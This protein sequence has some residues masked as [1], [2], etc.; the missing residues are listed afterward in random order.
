[1]SSLNAILNTSLTGLFTSQESLRVTSNNIANVNTPDYARLKVSQAATVL[2]GESVGVQVTEITR[3]VDE[4]LMT[5]LRNANSATGEFEIQAEFHDRIQG[6]LGKPESESSFSAQLEQVYAAIAELT[7]NPSDA[8]RRQQMMSEMTSFLQHMD[9][10]AGQIQD[11]RAE[12]SDKISES[13]DFANDAL[14]RISELNPLLARAYATGDET[15]GLEGLMDQALSELSNYMDITINR[16]SNGTVWVS[17]AS[18]ITLV[19]TGLSQ[20]KYSSPG[21]VSS[22]TSFPSITS[23]KVDKNTLEPL[24][25]EIDMTTHIRSGRIRGLMDL[26]DDQLVDLSLSLG[27]MAARV[28]DQ[29]NAVHNQFSSTPPLNTLTGK[30]TFLNGTDAPGFT[31]IATFAVADANGDLVAK[32]IVDF[33]TAP[34]ADMNALVTQ[35]NAGLGGAGTVS[36]TNGVLSFTAT[37]PSH[38]AVIADSDTAPTDR[39]GRGFSHFFG[40]ND[41]ILSDSEGIYETGLTGTEAHN[42]TAGETMNFSVY[43][44]TGRELT[45]ITVN[46][47]GTTYNDMIAE[48]NNVAGLGAYFSFSLDSK[49]ALQWNETANYDGL[50]LD[51]RSD[52][53][54]AGSTGMG[55]T[56]I[57]GMDPSAHARAAQNLTIRRDVFENP[58]LMSIGKFD[59]TAAVGSQ[60]LTPGD[61]RGAL[62][63][64]D[65]E[66]KFVDFASA[67]ELKNT[68]AT[69][70]QYVARFLGNAGQMATRA[71]NQQADNG[72]LRTELSQKNADVSG[73]NMDEELANLIVY[74]NAYNAAAR[75]LSSVQELYDALLQAV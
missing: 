38:G 25:N 40:M 48:L 57:F 59:H 9:Q 15:G 4:F 29:F 66:T 32:T 24:S 53:T 58:G 62:A 13:V 18:G 73:V 72:A 14:V 21:I 16:Q 20:L 61:Q 5:A 27:E 54:N 2:Q 70:S 17:S 44:N 46:V 55:F 33:D 8:L 1:M 52:S 10:L 35:I 41:L 34:P 28:K 67:G 68:N 19:D 49:G 65:I 74:Q 31:G 63:F 60:V 26:R 3:I 12:A 56:Q 22:E 47:T 39:G 71:A 36:F 75:M 64:Q 43:D 7:L 42:M 30:Q 11:L 23:F 45:N 37:D 51:V 50:R 69:L 6:I